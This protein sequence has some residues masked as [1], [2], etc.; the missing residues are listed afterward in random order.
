MFYATDR[1]R[2][3]AIGEFENSRSSDGSLALGRIDVSIPPAHRVGE[4]E[5]PSWWTIR[6][7]ST[8]D[9]FQIVNRTADTHDG[10]YTHVAARVTGSADRDAFVFIHGYNVS[11]D[12]AV[13]RTA[14]L[15]HD[16]SFKGAPISR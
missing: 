1:A 15:A 8:G 4:L 13:F 14:Q 12:D 7:S 3:S 9:F 10:F 16:L 6:R 11:F 5:R 2:T